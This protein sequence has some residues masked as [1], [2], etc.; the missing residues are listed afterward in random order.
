M[1][2]RLWDISGPYPVNTLTVVGHEHFNECYA[3]APYTSYHHLALLAGLKKTPP[4]SSTAEFMA[5]GSRDLPQ[6]THRP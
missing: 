1:T 2:A 4:A 3:L 5:T 6:N